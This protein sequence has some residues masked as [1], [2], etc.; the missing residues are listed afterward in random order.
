MLALSSSVLGVAQKAEEVLAAC[1]C[2][3]L[4]PQHLPNY[5][6]WFFKLQRFL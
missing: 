3:D 4:G 1:I 6:I 2:I 5:R